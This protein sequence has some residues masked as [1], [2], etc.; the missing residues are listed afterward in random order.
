MREGAEGNMQDRVDDLS[1]INYREWEDLDLMDLS[2]KFYFS[3]A[4][5][6]SANWDANRPDIRITRSDRKVNTDALFDIASIS[7]V[8]LS[9]LIVKML[10]QEDLNL[11]E[12]VV[13]GFSVR[14]FLSYS[15]IV[16]Q[17]SWES[18]RDF[19]YNESYNTDTL[20]KQIRSLDFTS[21]KAYYS[22]MPALVLSLYLQEKFGK[23]LT[24]LMR[25]YLPELRGMSISHELLSDHEAFPVTT[26]DKVPTIYDPS[27]RAIFEKGVET[28]HGGV[29][30]SAKHMMELARVN[31]NLA[32]E[33]SEEY[34][35]LNILFKSGKEPLYLLGWFVAPK[36]SNVFAGMSTPAWFKS[37]FSGSFVTV[38]PG[39][40]RAVIF[41]SDMARAR[42]KYPGF[43]NERDELYNLI[44]R[45]AKV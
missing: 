40:N 18:F 5:A 21:S 24:E 3:Y 45:A 44:L 36:N 8:I 14:D 15:A 11:D 32:R 9:T 39:S 25:M 4:L 26:K 10:L 33:F 13:Q 17:K 41:L 22:N 7:K 31:L 23:T 20:W 29:F 42:A 35:K 38:L 1:F 37:S 16:K 27:T 30:A 43:S 2:E 28:L 12:E 34:S 19:L 6:V